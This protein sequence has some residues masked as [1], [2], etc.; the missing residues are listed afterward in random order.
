MNPWGAQ[1][2]S[3]EDCLKNCQL[4]VEIT[5]RAFIMNDYKKGKHVSWDVDKAIAKCVELCQMLALQNMMEEQFE[6]EDVSSMR[7]GVSMMVRLKSLQQY[8]FQVYFSR[9]YF[10]SNPCIRY[11]GLS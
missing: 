10:L 6:D 4:E 2:A 9:Y 7:V 5:T 11:V 1:I 8:I 3:L